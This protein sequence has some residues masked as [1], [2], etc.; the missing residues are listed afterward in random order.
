MAGTVGTGP[1]G[2]S[3]VGTSPVGTSPVEAGTVGTGTAG[4]G[5]PLRPSV[6]ATPLPQ[7]IT[8]TQLSTGNLPFL[9]EHRVHGYTVV[10]GVAYLEL[11]L[12]SASG[13]RR[14]RRPSRTWPSINHWSCPMENCA[15]CR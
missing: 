12:A 2:T 13:P 6:F 7:T 15:K 11:L 5:K 14:Q 1:V 9:S 3:P 4:P 10:P 8:C